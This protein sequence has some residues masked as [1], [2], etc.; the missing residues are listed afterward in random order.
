[1]DL[2]TV[3]Q[4]SEALVLGVSADTLGRKLLFSPSEWAPDLLEYLGEARR[5]LAPEWT[6]ARQAHR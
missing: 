2:E 5:D 1:M 6:T 3:K 4:R